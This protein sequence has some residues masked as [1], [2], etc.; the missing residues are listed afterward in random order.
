MSKR[1]LIADDEPIIVVLAKLRLEEHGYIVETARNGKE[2]MRVLETMTVDLIVLDVIM[3][4]M[5]GVDVYK[6][7]KKNSRLANMPVVIMTDNRIFRE[8]FQTLG[9]EHFLPKPLD[10]EKLLHKVD[11]IFTCSNLERK[12]KQTLILSSDPE[13]SGGMARVLEGQGLVVGKSSDPIDFVSTALILAPKLV[14]VDVMIGGD[15]PSY[16]VVR[17]LRSFTRLR[18]MKI[19]VFTDIQP[20]DADSAERL[21]DLRVGKDLCMTAEADKYIGRF[22]PDTLW[23]MVREYCS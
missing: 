1:I 6:E 20:E 11:Y 9:V 5:D 15:I 4:V 23:E 13:V 21:D 12:N 17:G 16:E 8:S 18:E 7:L 19:L 2:A 3:P 22:S 14:L 10:I